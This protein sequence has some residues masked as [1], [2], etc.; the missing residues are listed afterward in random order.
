MQSG[1]LKEVQF[2]RA[3]GE[4]TPTGERVV[5]EKAL[6][7]FVDGRHCATAM[8][9]A[10]LE[11]EY[12]TGYLYVQ[13]LIHEATDIASLEITNDIARVSLKTG[14]E[15]RSFPRNI[16][17]NLKIS[18]EDI[19]R[20]V[21]AILKSPVF[22]ETEAVHSAGLFIAGS[23]AISL[24]EDLGRHNAMDKVIGAALLQKVD[25][26]RTLATSTGRQPAEMIFKYLSAGIPIIATKGVPTSKAVEL[27]EKSGITIVGMVRGDFM[28]VYS[29]PERIQ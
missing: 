9:L 18:K 26:S 19:F 25:F 21:R 28:I 14:I 20:S 22:E 6:S 23:K 15:K 24:A 7:M 5:R 3:D 12:I 2:T 16:T 13:G 10:T 17:S 8:I 1:F 4:L 29:H 27:A 11:K